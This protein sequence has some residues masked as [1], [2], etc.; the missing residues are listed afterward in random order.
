MENVFLEIVE[1]KKDLI[2]EISKIV[3]DKPYQFLF[4]NVDSQRMFKNW[5]ELILS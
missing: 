3:F 4:I 1:Q 5:D 2:P